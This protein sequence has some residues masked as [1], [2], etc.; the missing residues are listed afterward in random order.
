MLWSTELSIER[1]AADDSSN[2]RLN[3]GK[4][5]DP[6][7]AEHSVV[8]YLGNYVYM[9]VEPVAFRLCDLIESLLSGRS[10]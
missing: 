8:N 1:K 3:V 4:P 9:C 5:F 10:C 7:N 6:E 2:Q